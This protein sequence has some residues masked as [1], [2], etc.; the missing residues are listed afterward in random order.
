VLLSETPRLED[1]WWPLTFSCP[2]L[3]AQLADDYFQFMYDFYCK[4]PEFFAFE[5]YVPVRGL[6]V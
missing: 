1:Q 5:A 2:D 3:L 4:N 6:V